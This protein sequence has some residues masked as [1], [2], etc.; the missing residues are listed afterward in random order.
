ME[1][2][3]EIAFYQ[4][5][6]FTDRPFRGN[7][8]AVFLHEEPL[9][10]RAM[11]MVAREM[12]LSETAFVGPERDGAR[13]I[14]WFT[15][16][17]EVS[18]CGHA[19]LAA[20]HVLMEEAHMK[21]PVHLRSPAGTITVRDDDGI[22]SMAF[23]ADPAEIELPPS[24]LLRALGCHEA[25]PVLRSDQ[26]WMVRLSWGKE[27]EA[28]TPNM[29]RLLEADVG[30]GVLGVA[31]TAPGGGDVDFVSRFFAPWVG[32]PEV[33]KSVLDRHDGG[34]ADDVDADA[35]VELG[36][37]DL[38]ATAAIVGPER[39]AELHARSGGLPLLLAALTVTSDDGTP[40]TIHDAIA[41]RIETL[42]VATTT[43]SA[44]AVLGSDVDL[45]LL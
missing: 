27:V 45:D 6:A 17:V 40:T 7:P 14:R 24:G 36:P 28:L 35:I 4:V 22:L 25:V 15:P 12:N 16:A 11:Q 10:P 19:T 5:D 38:D 13:E 21:G 32:I 9:D 23:P 43:L 2:G 1:R 37:L 41:R 31:V 30:D 3:P 20:G 34:R 8:A 26:I 42:G 44:A 39:A 18:A 29:S 33:L